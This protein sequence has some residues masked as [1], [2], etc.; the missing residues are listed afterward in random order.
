MP[1]SLQ[2]DLVN[3]T[4]ASASPIEANYNLIEQY[5]N[6]DVITRDGATAMSAQ[7]RLLGNPVND[8]DAAPKG[9][10]DAILPI[11][12]LMIYGGLTAP[13]GG[14]WALANGAELETV[15]Y[16][17]LYAILGTRFVPGTPAAGRFNLP[18]MADRTPVGVGTNTALGGTGGNRDLVVPTHTHTIDHAHPAG[19]T[20]NDNNFHQHGGV[21]HFHAFTTGTESTNHSHT[22]V[23]DIMASTGG[24]VVSGLV[25]DWSYGGPTGAAT[26]NQS[27]LHTHSGTTGAADRELTTGNQ[28]VYHQHV[29]TT[30]VHAG[31]SGTTGTTPT[32]AN[33]PPFVGVTY[34]IRV[35]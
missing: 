15:A 20:G 21:D 33:M 1:L 19:T 30:P 28:S 17:E 12:I 14:R 4:P 35:N 31:S 2:Y 3:D 8:L 24:G 9:Y 25:K 27:A 5:V 26:G 16:P 6:Q 29:F 18:N 7:L 13:P 10:V 22:N 34:I 11:G 23:I 32:G